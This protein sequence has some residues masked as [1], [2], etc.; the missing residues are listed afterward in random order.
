VDLGS[1]DRNLGF[2]SLRAMA[3]AMVEESGNRVGEENSI[4]WPETTG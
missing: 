2:R 4:L 3:V 1:N